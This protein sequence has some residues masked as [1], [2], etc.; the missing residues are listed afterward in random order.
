MIIGPCI[1]FIPL[2]EWSVETRD[3][4]LAQRP[5]NSIRLICKPA[6]FS[7]SPSS[8]FRTLQWPTAGMMKT[9]ATFQKSQTRMTTRTKPL[10]RSQL[11]HRQLLQPRVSHGRPDRRQ[12]QRPPR[13]K[14][15]AGQ[16]K[17]PNRIYRNLSNPAI[18]LSSCTVSH[19]QTF[20][21][22]AL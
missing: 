6:V 14:P 18:R 4:G 16:P 1:S 3:K 5:N 9:S 17:L 12:S 11:S 19:I 15:E 2:N 10:P 20:C 8:L 13:A 21:D 22:T 7:S